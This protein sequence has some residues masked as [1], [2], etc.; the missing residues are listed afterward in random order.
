[1]RKNTPVWSKNANKILIDKGMKKTELSKALD[2]NYRQLCNVMSGYVVND[3]MELQIC[4]Y[5]GIE[6]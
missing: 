3:N 1:M 6:R 2:V 5:L 4:Q